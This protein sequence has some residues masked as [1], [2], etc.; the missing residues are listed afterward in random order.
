V[1][2][3]VAAEAIPVT[4]R[5]NE[6]YR[7]A[8]RSF[9]DAFN[10]FVKVTTAD[11]R[12]GF[13]CASPGEEVT[14][15]TRDGCLAALRDRLVPLLRET[16]AADPEE[17]ARR[18]RAAGPGT[19]A[20]RAAAETALWDLLA[21]RAGAPL[22]RL[23]GIRRGFIATSVTLGVAGERETLERARRRVAEGFRILKIKIGEDWRK[24][25]GL[26]RRLRAALGPG[27]TLRADANQGYGEQ[28]ARDF[29]RA[30]PPGSIELLEQPVAARDTEALRRITADHRVPI[31][32]DEAV[33]DGEDA[34]RI[35]A[36]R[37][38]GQ[39][40]LKLMKTG[41]LVEAQRVGRVAAK[42][43]LR[44]MIG[45]MDE[46][47]LGIAAALHWALASPVVDRA[48]LDGHLDLADDVARGGFRLRDG[49]L[50]PLY[51]QA[52]LGVSV[53]L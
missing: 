6:A 9:H 2:R 5:L 34:A 42:T 52:G 16:D 40:N 1:T 24:D 23:L 38:A 17:F 4:F 51:D 11:G 46:S 41:G 3:I 53:D 25:A 13:G 12:T 45:C 15:E 33:L 19:P 50:V 21:R 28:A 39:I 10:V 36:L 29:L 47:R 49:R 7:I 43:G 27:I 48:D 31:M 44:L 20:A 37:A 22:V 30:L 26:V 18:A 32:A 8:G 35:A 14:G